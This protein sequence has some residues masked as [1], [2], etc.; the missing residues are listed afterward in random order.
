M[1]VYSKISV[2][3]EV[4]KMKL[5]IRGVDCI[6]RLVGDALEQGTVFVADDV[7][8]VFTCIT[9]AMKTCTSEIEK[10]TEKDY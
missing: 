6:G 7:D 3:G 8:G 10:I 5:L 1:T 9:T 2:Q 4:E